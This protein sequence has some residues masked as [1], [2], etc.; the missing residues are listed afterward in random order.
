MTLRKGKVRK[1]GEATSEEDKKFVFED[2]EAFK[3][4]HER[5]VPPISCS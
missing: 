1:D 3:I 2:G 4:M 5:Q